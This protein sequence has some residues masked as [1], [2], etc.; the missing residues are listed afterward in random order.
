MASGP[1]GAMVS[2]VEPALCPVRAPGFVTEPWVL[3]MATGLM[4]SLDGPATRLC[5]S[6]FAGQVGVVAAAAWLVDAVTTPTAM[7]MTT[8]AFPA[9]RVCRCPR[10]CFLIAEMSCILSLLRKAA[11]SAT[12]SRT[13]GQR[14]RGVHDGVW[15][16]AVEVMLVRER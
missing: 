5:Q 11:A 15:M 3:T 9:V 14:H 16:A 6:G 8:K 13:L 10:R 2:V 7:T 1:P 4:S 12:V